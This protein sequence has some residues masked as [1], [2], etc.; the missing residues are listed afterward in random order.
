MDTRTLLVVGGTGR[1]GRRLVTQAL[2][3]GMTPTVLGRSAHPDDVPEGAQAVRGDVLEPGALAAAMEGV[4]AVVTALSI[5]R[6]S[7]S[8]FSAPTGPPDLHSRAAAAVI[9]AMAAHG[10][11]RLVKISAQGV[12]SSAPRTGWAFRALV[13]ASSLRGAFADHAHAD[14]LLQGSALDWTIVRPPALIDAPPGIPLHAAP[15]RI[16]WSWTRARTGDLAC[17][18]LDALDDPATFGQTLTLAP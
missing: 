12:G 9:E 4:D 10:I 7:R 11:Q 17:W 5:P 14:A 6:T 3:R 16:T 1:T 15:D 2:E 18:I 8:P 13:A